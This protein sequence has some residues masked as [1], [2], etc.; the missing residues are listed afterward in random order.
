MEQK[1]ILNEILNVLKDHIQ[2]VSARFERLENHMNE[3]FEQIDKRFEQIDKK[4]EQINIRFERL[5]KRFDQLDNKVNGM[6]MDIMDN[7][8]TTNFILSKIAQ[9]DEKL[10]ELSQQRK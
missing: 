4:F 5:E 10:L 8:K 1:T 6:R 3:K 7:Q 9:H 2:Q